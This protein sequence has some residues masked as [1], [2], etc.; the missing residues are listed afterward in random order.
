MFSEWLLHICK[1]LSFYRKAQMVEAKI[2]LYL[3]LHV[4]NLICM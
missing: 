3:N 4:H 1:N 2:N